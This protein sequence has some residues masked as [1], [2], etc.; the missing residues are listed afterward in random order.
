MRAAPYTQEGGS[1]GVHF[2]YDNQSAYEIDYG[3]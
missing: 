2:I 1:Y 3:M